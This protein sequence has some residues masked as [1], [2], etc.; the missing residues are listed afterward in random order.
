MTAIRREV[1]SLEHEQG[2]EVSGLPRNELNELITSMIWDA[3]TSGKSF[4]KEI[5][6]DTYR[7]NSNP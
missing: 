5:W 7:R 3:F 1:I 4:L 6:C 2:D